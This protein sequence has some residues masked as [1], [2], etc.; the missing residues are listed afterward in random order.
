MPSDIADLPQVPPL[1]MP[2]SRN[3]TMT[4]PQKA[5]I[6]VRLLASEDVK[7]PLSALPEHMQV[8][9]AESIGDLHLVQRDAIATIVEEF[10]Q[11]LNAVGF[12][13]SGG[14]EAALNVLD[15]SLSH[16]TSEKMRRDIGLRAVSD[17]WERLNALSTEALTPLI[18]G[19]SDEVGAVILSKLKVSKSAEIIAS[20]PGQQARRIAYAMSLT[21]NVTPDAVDRIGASL[22]RQIDAIPESAFSQDPAELIGSILNSSPTNTREDILDGLEQTDDAFASQVKRAIFTFANIPERVDARDVPK[23]FRGL[24]QDVVVSALVAAKATGLDNAA[25]HLLENLSKRMASQLEEAMEERQ[26]LSPA[27]GDIA[28]ATVVTEIRRLA[29]DGEI[30]LIAPEE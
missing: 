27:D 2:A 16:Q 30:H 12:A 11:E 7:L 1:P 10:L 13:N 21:N 20:L 18:E 17:P 24:D 26:D 25:T 6:L 28:M 22:I 23:I 4:Q 15:G 14:I 9:L 5:A 29:S 8:L 19:E 3:V